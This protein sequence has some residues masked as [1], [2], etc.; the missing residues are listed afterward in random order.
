MD[1][2]S[3]DVKQFAETLARMTDSPDGAVFTSWLR[4]KIALDSYDP[5]NPH[6]TSRNEGFRAAFREILRYIEQGRSKKSY[7]TEAQT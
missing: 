2:E 3:L 4:A 1:V 5:I 6:N 7:P